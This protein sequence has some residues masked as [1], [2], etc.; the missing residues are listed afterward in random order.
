MKKKIVIACLGYDLSGGG[1]EHVALQLLNL[2][3]R[4]LFSIELCYLRNYGELH[5]MVPSDLRPV[6][7]SGSNSRFRNTIAPAFRGY[8][9]I[10]KRAD[11]LFGMMEG[12]PI[13]LASL[14]GSIEGKPS[15]GWNHTTA[16]RSFVDLNRLHQ[17]L[18]P[19]LYPHVSQMIC[20]SQGAR[21]DLMHL[22]RFKKNPPVTIHNPLDR[23][24]VR[25]KSADPLPESAQ[26]WYRRSVVIGVGRLV[27]EKRTDRLIH[28]FAVATR[29]GLNANLVLLGKGPLRERHEKLSE[30]LGIASR[31]FFAGFQANPYP[32]IKAASVLALSSEYEGLGMVLL[33]AMALGTPVVS[34]DCPNG[35]REILQDGR[36]GILTPVG[37]SEAM[38]VA[39]A[40]MV[41]NEETR[42]A[43]VIHGLERV[44][45]FDS[46][47]I[48]HQ[49]E[50]LFLKLARQ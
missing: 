12:I 17:I 18:M 48:V 5:Q 4:D 40:T 3:D 9:A 32:Y 50:S 27:E 41:S 31:V 6:F 22:C 26:G 7:F 45:D 34:V 42:R 33:E 25:T 21:K 36:S 14:I 23:E 46:V 28:A 15:I 16:S 20:V 19:L 10:A 43:C 11:L 35:P 38:A 1:A 30:E 29:N 37:D 24:Y 49:F 13:Y 8:R 2:L 44:E 39:I 47:R